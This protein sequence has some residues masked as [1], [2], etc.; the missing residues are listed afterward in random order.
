M[1]D[2]NAAANPKCL[3]CHPQARGGLLACGH[4]HESP[5][6]ELV[7][8]CLA[9]NAGGLGM[10]F[11]RAQVGFVRRDWGFRMF[12]SGRREGRRPPEQMV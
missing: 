3:R 11:G 2:G 10:P 9:L 12:R 6:A 7:G 8:G 4:I 1:H 5:G